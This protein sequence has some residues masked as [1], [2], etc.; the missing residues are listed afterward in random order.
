[1]DIG[2]RAQIERTLSSELGS[3]PE[4]WC[5]WSEDDHAVIISYTGVIG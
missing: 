3:Y 2:Q 1:M 5:A 4:V